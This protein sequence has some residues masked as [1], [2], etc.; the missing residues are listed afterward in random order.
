MRTDPEPDA[1]TVNF[2]RQGAM[3]GS[4]AS[5]PGVGANRFEVEARM[6]GVFPQQAVILPRQ[7]ANFTG[8]G[9]VVPPEVRG[10]RMPHGSGVQR[11]A[12]NSEIAFCASLSSG[13]PERASSSI[14]ASH[15]S[16]QR[17]SKCAFNC[18]NSF[19]GN[20]SIAASI[21]CTVLT[22]SNYR[23]PQSSSTLNPQLS[24]LNQT[25]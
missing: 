14:C 12:L 8:Q 22:G 24:T 25:K 2:R 5:G 17:R 11:P 3:L 23:F 21:S 1:S 16:S 7:P 15:S 9:V 13:P 20:F 10:G 6:F 18:H 4:H 19:R